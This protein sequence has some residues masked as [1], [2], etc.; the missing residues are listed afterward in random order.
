[1]IS[2]FFMWR[3]FIGPLLIVYNHSRKLQLRKKF[4]HYIQYMYMG[5]MDELVTIAFV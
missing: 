3:Y 1:M 2:T 4:L 5:R